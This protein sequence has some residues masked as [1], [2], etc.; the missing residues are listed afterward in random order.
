MQTF[1]SLPVGTHFTNADKSYVKVDSNTGRL[2][3][4]FTLVKFDGDVL[5]ERLI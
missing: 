3:G 4:T 2:F 1:N 5:C